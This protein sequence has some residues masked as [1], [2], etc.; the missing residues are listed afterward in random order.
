MQLISI[1]IPAYNEEAVLPELFKQLNTVLKILRQFTFE[2]IVVENG[3][4]DNTLPVSLRHRKKDPRIK[5][6]Q[7]AKNEGCDGAIIAGL[8]YAKGKAAIVMMADL[9]DDPALIPVFLKKWQEGYDM[10]YGIVKKRIGI[11]ITRRAGTYLFYKLLYVL[12]KGTLPEN[13]SDFRLMDQ[14]VYKLITAIPEHNKF[15]RGLVIWTGYKHAGIPFERKK[16]FAGKSKANFSNVLN[17]AITGIIAF[18]NFPLRIPWLIGFISLFF[19]V[20]A[21]LFFHMIIAGFILF[22]FSILC[23]IIAIQGEYIL[24]ILEEVRNRPNFIVSKQYGLYSLSKKRH[25]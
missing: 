18:S 4:E 3:S 1:V 5:I 11:P 20:I 8:T 16:R 23:S 17:T 21:M 19:C 14:K 22:L 6:L 10:V 15:F 7:L 24:R 9:Q 12:T 13:V 2:I 25:Q